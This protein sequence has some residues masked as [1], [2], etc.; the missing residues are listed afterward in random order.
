[1]SAHLSNRLI[2]AAFEQEMARVKRTCE[3]AIDQVADA[4]LHTQ[5]SPRQNSLAAIIQHVAG[6]MESRFT[7]FLTT[8]G[9][10][11]TRNREAE[12][13]DRHLPR[14]DLMALWNRGWQ[15]TFAA[16]AP[17]TD[18]DLHRTITIRNEPHTVALA[19]ARQLGHQGW[20]AGQIL[21]L[22]KHLVGDRWQY[23]TIAPGGTASFNKG[24]GL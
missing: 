10:K 6:N 2:I 22:A 21:L 4:D 14:P 24:K 15:C 9:E 17:L 1:M 8:D 7:D 11:P 20:H 18:A 3:S 13:A 16:L 19:L 23:V 5:L 12:F